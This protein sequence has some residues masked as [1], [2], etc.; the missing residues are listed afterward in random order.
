MTL[1]SVSGLLALDSLLLTFL[2]ALEPSKTLGHAHSDQ[3][4]VGPM[5]PKLIGPT[6]L[7]LIRR[8]ARI[9]V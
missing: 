4:R 8:M 7:R 9:F 5:T 3:A 1:V 2:S 6:W